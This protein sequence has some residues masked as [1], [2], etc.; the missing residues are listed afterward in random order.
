MLH[1]TMIYGAE[2]EDNVQRLA[3]MLR[4]LPVVPLPGGGRALV[5]P[6][7]QD[8]V[9]RSLRAAIAA[10]WHRPETMVL[11]GADRV[12]YAEFVRAVAQAA[13]LPRPRIVP[14]PARLLRLATP[15]TRLLPG[16]PT[17]RRAEVQRLLEDKSW[18]IDPM[19]RQ[20]GVVP[21]GLADGLARTFG[22]SS[23]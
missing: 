11:A 8:D 19:R 1:P 4:R 10:E 20:L 16:V 6:I 22:A 9:T 7:H 3:R 5:R 14:L 17:I 12:S 15:L 2:G 21:V 23:R 18:G 13:G